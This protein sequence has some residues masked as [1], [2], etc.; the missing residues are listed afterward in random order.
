M[1]APW[2]GDRFDQ[3]LGTGMSSTAPCHP[4]GLPGLEPSDRQGRGTKAAI[5]STGE[6]VAPFRHEQWEQH[7]LRAATPE[8]LPVW[9]ICIRIVA[10]PN[11]VFGGVTCS[12]PSPFDSCICKKICLQ[13]PLL[14]E[15]VSPVIHVGAS[16]LYLLGTWQEA[17]LK[18][19]SH[20]RAVFKGG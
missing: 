11:A 4:T 12:R 15:F 18:C 5:H 14:S 8:F 10:F 20:A 9:L 19:G 1:L 7:S 3:T 16:D 13:P 6:G 17:G 2:A